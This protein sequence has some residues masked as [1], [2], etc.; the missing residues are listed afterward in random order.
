M[1]TSIRTRRSNTST[2][3]DTMHTTGTRM[4][5]RSANRIRIGTATRRCATPIR[6]TLTCITGTAMAEPLSDAERL[7]DRRRHAEIGLEQPAQKAGR[8]G[9]QG[10]DRYLRIDLRSGDP[11]IGGEQALPFATEQQR[12][13][14]RNDAE[15][16]VQSIGRDDRPLQVE[17]VKAEVR[18]AVA[19]HA[20]RPAIGNQIVEHEAILVIGKI[21]AQGAE[22]DARA[23][24]HTAGAA[25]R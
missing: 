6:T 19:G 11:V 15:D 3:I 5:G 4:R 7:P 10:I 22:R 23:G 18:H 13:D 1:S 21:A 16:G 14:N 12:T 8:E 20:D 24:E 17:P 9:A 2:A 25:E